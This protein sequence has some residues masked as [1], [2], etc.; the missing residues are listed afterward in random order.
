MWTSLGVRRWNH[1]AQPESATRFPNRRHQK[2]KRGL[3]IM[4]VK[5][6]PQI[7]NWKGSHGN[8]IKLQAEIWAF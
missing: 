4:N 1:G 8:R 3:R 7:R 5:L 6:G 2:L